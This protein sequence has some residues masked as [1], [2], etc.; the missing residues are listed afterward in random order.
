MPGNFMSMPNN[1]VPVTM[2]WLSTPFTAVPM[3]LKSFGSLSFTAS[4]AGG[5]TAAAFSRSCVYGIE[6]LLA[7]CRTVPADVSSSASGTLHVCAAA[8]TSIVRAAAPTRRIGSQFVGVAVLP[9]A[10]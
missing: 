10:P 9:P 3:I 8:V 4:S 5:V 2:A 1:G 6:R 7:L